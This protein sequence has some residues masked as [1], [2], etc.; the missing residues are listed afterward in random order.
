[1]YPCIHSWSQRFR[2]DCAIVYITRCLDYGVRICHVQYWC[3]VAAIG[4]DWYKTQNIPQLP[5]FGF[6]FQFQMVIHHS[7]HDWFECSFRNAAWCHEAFAWIVVGCFQWLI[8]ILQIA[9]QESVVCCQ[10]KV[11]RTF[12]KTTVYSVL[13]ILVLH[14]HISHFSSLDKLGFWFPVLVSWRHG[15]HD[16]VPIHCLQHHAVETSRQFFS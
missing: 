13:Q 11:V 16:W 9:F 7:R 10:V 5:C 3:S 14:Q 8:L 4:P 6:H 1:M 12:L 15:T 2:R